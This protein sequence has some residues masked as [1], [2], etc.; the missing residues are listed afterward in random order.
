MKGN[1][2][3]YLQS[4]RAL[5]ELGESLPC[6]VRVLIEGNEESNPYALDWVA[7]QP[8]ATNSTPMPW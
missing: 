2:L 3:I 6:N 8:C 5:H 7:E 4:L 1:L